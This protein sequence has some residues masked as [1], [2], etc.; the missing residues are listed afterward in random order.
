MAKNVLSISASTK[1]IDR[2]T[3]R[4]FVTSEYESEKF[5]SL[6]RAMTIE[7]RRHIARDTLLELVHI[8][9][10]HTSFGAHLLAHLA[11]YYMIVFGNF[12][13]AIPEIEKAVKSQ[14]DDSLLRHIHGDIIR[15]HVQALKNK[16]QIDMLMIVKHAIQ[17][18]DCFAFVR[19]KRPY[20]SHGFISDSMVRIT[21]MQAAIKEMGGE[22]QTSFIDYLIQMIDNMKES[23][24][25]QL[26][27]NK[28][29]LLSLIPDVHQFLNEGVIDPDHKEKWK[30]EFRK[31]IGKPENLRRLCDKIQEQ[32][33]LFEKDDSILLHQVALQIL[34]LNNSLEI[35]FKPLTPVQIERLVK[36]VY[37]PDSSRTITDQQMKFWLRHSRRQKK[38]PNL[39]EIR[40]Q[41]KNWVDMKKGGISPDAE[42]YK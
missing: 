41:V 36:E 40:K 37:D 9:P 28:R 1:S 11:K 13:K 39:E 10:D 12:E 31:C 21:V 25:Y 4:L 24:N 27:E 34:I 22:K 38:V 5:S 18:S 17:S 32:K 33:H 7:K 3:R 19:R 8:F 6:I 2:L 42:F 16:N 15:I 30:D 23:S 29:Y 35:E 20:V 26:L 14:K